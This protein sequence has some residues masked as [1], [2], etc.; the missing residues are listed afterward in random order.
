MSIRC[1]LFC[2]VIDN[3][4]DIGVCWRLARQLQR[5]HGVALTLWV[6]DLTVFARLA[7]G[8]DTQAAAQS[9]DGLTVRHWRD[10]AAIN[11]VPGQLVIEAFACELPAV[12]VAAMAA[13]SPPPVWLNLEY[14]SAESWVEDCH[15]LA[16]VHAATGLPKHFWFPGFTA[17]TGGLLRE[18]ELLSH[19]DR[20]QMDSAAE[21]AFWQRIGVPDAPAFQRRVSLFAYENPAIAGLLTAL[22]E[23]REPALL[24]VPEGRALGDV[25]AWAKARSLNNSHD[26]LS[27]S[28]SALNNSLGALK[29]GDRIE[30]GS[31]T[32]AVLPLLAHEDYDRLLWA[33]PL[34]A[35]RG[36]DSFIRAQWAGHPLLWHIYPQEEEAH[37]AKL[38]AFIQQVERQTAMP[39][40]WAEAMRAWNKGDARPELWA[41]L[42]ADL[43]QLAPPARDWSRHLAGQTDLA[44]GVMHFY[45]RQ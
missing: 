4:G 30:Q 26:S 41:A 40:V 18:D 21:A 29:A 8:L 35:V 36:E 44:S 1:D 13:Q 28:R 12:F 45:R 20:F 5:E 25:A 2:R 16:S 22:A 27:N 14:L 38:E 19:R 32:V 23:D 3:Y 43:P 24:L 37:L 34:N 42:V 10:D 17:R 33:C 7:P 39:A 9:L 31:L 15:G 6:D 11:A